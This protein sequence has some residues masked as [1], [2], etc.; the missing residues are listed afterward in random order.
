MAHARVAGQP[1]RA[2]LRIA[3]RGRG[4]DRRRGASVE[5]GAHRVDPRDLE[6]GRDAAP[7]AARPAAVGDGPPPRDRRAGAG[8]QRH[9]HRRVPGAEPH[10]SRRDLDAARPRAGGSHVADHVPRC[11]VGLD[12]AAE[13]D[14]DPV[15]RC[16]RVRSPGALH[17]QRPHGCRARDLTAVPRER[18]PVRVSAA[19]R[20]CTRGRDGEVRRPACRRS[21]RAAPHHALHHGAHDAA[22]DRRSSPTCAPSSSRR[23][24]GSSSAAR[25]RR[26]G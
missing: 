2:S 3:R 20:G 21:D 26:S 4:V 8:R 9:P 15:R 17:G 5:R 12:R 13:A 7:V 22:T 11:L 25:R 14:R 23:S 16:R 18:L 10:R 6:A 24:S 1:D 19:A